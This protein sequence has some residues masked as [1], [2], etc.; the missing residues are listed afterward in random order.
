MGKF[1]E[2]KDTCLRH[3]TI[4]VDTEPY[5]WF[6]DASVEMIG[7]CEFKIEVKECN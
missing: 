5:R 1:C 3:L 6:F 2:V 4:A 7:D